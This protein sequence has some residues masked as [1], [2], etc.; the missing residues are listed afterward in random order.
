MA[1]SV[2]QFGKSLVASGLMTGEDVKALWTEIPAGE[3]PKDDDAFAKLLVAQKKLTEFQATELLASRGA[4]LIMGEYS[5]LAEIGAGGMGNVYKA[6][7]R[8]M[9]RVVALKVMSGTAMK[10]EG[11]V[12]RF[13]RE[14]QAAARLEHP[15]I[16]T[17][18]DSGEAGNVKY[19]VMQFVDGSD[20][21]DLVKKNGPCSVERAVDYVLQAA[22]GLAFAHAEG[23]IHRDIKPANLLLDKKGVVKILDMG[24]ARIE[25]GDDGLTATEQVMGTVDFMSPEQAANTKTADAR[26]DIYSLGCTLWFLLT[27]KKVYEADSMIGRLMA[28]RDGPLPSLVKTR[29]DVPWALEQAFHKMIA[30]RPQDRLQSMDEVIAALEPFAGSGSSGGGSRSGSGAG[31]NAE[32]ASFMNAMG[33]S[34]TK[35][36]PSTAQVKSA[37]S[38]TS[39][40]A[41]LDATAQFDKA[42]AD[43]DPKSQ[44]LPAGAG[45]ASAA[46]VAPPRAGA[47]KTKSPPRKNVK[48]IAGG[49]IGAVLLLVAGI[50]VTV[51]DKDGNVVAEVNVPSGASVEV[52]PTPAAPP[53]AGIS[54]AEAQRNRAAAEWCLVGTGSCEIVL[55]GNGAFG[56]TKVLNKSAL[57]REPFYVL[58]IAR[59]A[60]PID[61]LREI[62]GL[63]RL[64]EI[65]VTNLGCSDTALEQLA[66]LPKLDSLQ[67][68]GGR[69]TD[70]GM[71]WVATRLTSLRQ[72]DLRGNE[73]ITNVGLKHL[74]KLPGLDLVRLG[75]TGVTAAGVAELK[76]AFPNCNV[77]WIEPTTVPSST[78]PTNVATTP[79]TTVP[80][81]GWSSLFNGRDLTNWTPQGFNGWS[82]A[83]GVLVGRTTGNAFGWLMSDRDYDDFEFECEYK[84]GPNSNSGVFFRAWPEGNMSGADFQEVQLLD[85]SAKR[86]ETTQSKTRTGAIFGNV[87]PSPEVR[88]PAGQWHQFRLAAFKT[89]ARISI[90]GTQVVATELIGGKRSRGRLGLQLYPEQIE[91]RNLR[92]RE[93]N[94]DGTPRTTVPTGTTP[95]GSAAQGDYNLHFDGTANVKFDEV[96]PFAMDSCT[97]EAFVRPEAFVSSAV[98]Y[99]PSAT[100]TLGLHVL[101]GDRWT[102]RNVYLASGHHWVDART[103]VE[104][105]RL[106]HVA[107]VQDKSEFRLY[108]DG[109]LVGKAA[110]NPKDF[111]VQVRP[112]LIGDKFKG[113]I[114]EVRFSK[115][116]RYTADFTPKTRH[117]T[118][119][120]TLALYHCDEGTGNVLKDSSGYERHGNI[121]DA[122]WERSESKTAG[123]PALGQS[124]ATVDTPAG[125]A[126]AALSFNGGTGEIIIPNLQRDGGP[127]T[128]ECRVRD[129]SGKTMPIVRVNGRAPVQLH[130]AN[131]IPHGAERT[132]D[133]RVSRD[134]YGTTMSADRWT[135]LAHVVDAGESRLFVD[136]KLVKKQSGVSTASSTAKFDGTWIGSERLGGYPSRYDGK[137]DEIR[138][139]STARYD[140]D[141]EPEE[142]FT[143]DVHTLG[144]YHCDEGSGTE[145]LDSSSHKRHGQIV[146]VTWVRSGAAP[147]GAA[148]GPA[149]DLLSAIQIPRDVVAGNWM[150]QGSMLVT[151]PN[152]GGGGQ[153][154]LYLPTP[155][156]VPKSYDIELVI[157]RKVE[158]GT[159]MVF[160]LVSDGHQATVMMD[161]Y[162]SSGLWGIDDIDGQYIGQGTNSTKNP[163]R[164]LTLNERKTVRVE[165]RSDGVRVFCDAE[166]VVDWKG[167]SE[168]L[169]TKF[170]DIP[171]KQSLFLGSQGTFHIHSIRLTQRR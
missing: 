5:L 65:N 165:V 67:I 100:M 153:A 42:E 112:P 155:G 19:L 151:P 26:A 138:V 9:K 15:N 63:S 70:R 143:P 24:L 146:G 158:G 107:G 61:S 38:K 77:E 39:V 17:A 48:L 149:I 28:H 168:Q 84:I 148:V 55:V 120:N 41:Q 66:D 22:K 30:K 110:V 31:N 171:N 159:G 145:L 118:D 134:L 12:K 23:V 43:T 62:H 103:P 101:K 14:V 139:S 105:G 129:F 75:G 124:A 53:A 25:G 47:K 80:T 102:L 144:L 16:V 136:G 37:P 97:V 126:D 60:P 81:A 127:Y 91:F 59:G 10:D 72:I 96:I 109:T 157:E 13:Q 7:H 45:F 74:A 89:S 79:S 21:S 94:P 150:K 123:E 164:R 141:F 83:D 132:A 18:Y 71:Q 137:I 54:A 140:V 147:T 160:G 57:P 117:V 82:V 50:I 116:A 161:S 2:D 162:G 85:D 108:V 169:S 8:R 111:T 114:G 98:V 46:A 40:A 87:A 86:F 115:V 104:L 90:N 170:W 122:T 95:P 4:R 6:Q 58:K 68:A 51:R 52:K 33:S 156:P 78:T 121:I 154:R 167:R 1:A 34:P 152:G 56:S 20:L 32:L 166:K 73:G 125:V 49:L 64:F 88:P 142:R 35:A 133:D 163:G 119:E 131:R 130:S 11:A 99:S 113:T 69:I 27:A 128:L 44:V 76:K 92:V 36:G 93:L 106:V 29:D 3:R 135:H